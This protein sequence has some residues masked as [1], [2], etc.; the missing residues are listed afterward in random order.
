MLTGDN[1]TSADAVAKELG[2]DEVFAELLPEAKVK[3]IEELQR[4][5]HR[6]AMVGDGI[7]DGPALAKAD[8]GI[9]MGGGTQVALE[10]G[11]VALMTDDLSKIVLARAIA[12]RAYR[13]IQEN[14]FFGVGVVHVL[15]IA[16]ALLG[17]IGPIQAAVIHLGPDVL[18]FLNSVKLL[19]VRIET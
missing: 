1:R 14:L 2:V 17:W 9:A 8:V 15:G 6:V 16:A 19:R 13:T 5:P 12:R 10:A 7:N 4:H 18:V 3:A 11:D